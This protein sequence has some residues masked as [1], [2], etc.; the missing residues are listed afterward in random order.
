[1]CVLGIWIYS[2]MQCAHYE[3]THE[4]VFQILTSDAL[5]MF[6]P[7]SRADAL[8]ICPSLSRA[9]ALG[10]CPPL[11]RADAIDICPPLSRADG[12]VLRLFHTKIRS[13]FMDVHKCRTNSL[14]RKK[15]WTDFLYRQKNLIVFSFLL[16]TNEST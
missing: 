12:V 4:S 8:D 7:L 6:P 2:K 3:Q 16:R 5:D 1:M 14:Y 9:D 13:D 15:I 10:I 11:S